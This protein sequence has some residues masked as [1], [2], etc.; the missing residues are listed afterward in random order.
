M[1]AHQAK[2]RTDVHAGRGQSPKPEVLL[3]KTSEINFKN[4]EKRTP[5]PSRRLTSTLKCDDGTVTMSDFTHK[6]HP[7]AER[8]SLTQFAR[9]D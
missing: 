1:S 7:D 8:Q 2:Y 3:P 9:K 4:T 5:L 6:V